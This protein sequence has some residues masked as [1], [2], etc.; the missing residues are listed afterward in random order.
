MLRASVVAKVFEVIE[1]SAFTLADFI[2]D[3]P[4][5][6]GDKLLSIAFRHDRRFVFVLKQ[7]WNEK[8]YVYSALLAPGEFKNTEGLVVHS[9]TQIPDFVKSWTRHVRDELRAAIPIYSELDEIRELLEKHISQNVRDP[10]SRFSPAEVDE[11]KSKLDAL[12]VRFD[13]L[14]QRNE[15]T[16]QQ[17]SRLNQEL[18]AL[19]SN[20]TSYPK[21][22]WY[23]TAGAKL[24][25]TL[26]A[27][28]TSKESRLILAQQ[29]KK[30]LGLDDGAA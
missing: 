23:K 20:L 26:N 3:V 4:E 16:E 1:K 27:I 30:A 10:E 12:A 8:G 17:L 22:T 9:L 14:Q 2:V 24:Y 5:E 18:S 7:E 29:A 21:G 28:I 6:D 25:A 11:L 15:L 13:E 19:K